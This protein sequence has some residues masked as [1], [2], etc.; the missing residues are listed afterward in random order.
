M[1]S[2]QVVSGIAL[3]ALLGCLSGPAFAQTLQPNAQRE[4]EAILQEKANRTPA[5]QKLDSHIHLAGQLARGAL[6]TATIPSLANAAV[7]LEFDQAGS[8]HVDI[9]ANVNAAL[10][11]QITALGGRVE[12]SFPDYRVIRAWIPLLAAEA[13][14]SRSDVNFVKP[15]AK[16]IHNGQ[17]LPGSSPIPRGLTPAQRRASIRRQLEA[18]VPAFAAKRALRRGLALFTRP[19][20][21]SGEVSEGV[22][23]ELSQG[24]TGTGVKIG[25][26]SDGVKSLA[27]LQAAG[28]LPNNVTVLSGQAGPPTGDEGT[29]MLEIIYDLAPNATLYFATADGGEAQ[30]ATNIQNLAVAGCSIIVDDV[31][32]FDEGVFQDGII[33]QAVNAVTASGVLYFSAAGNSGNLDSGTSGTWEGDFTP[34]GSITITGGKFGAG[35]TVP[36]HAFD[37]THI[38][39][40]ITV[41]SSNSSPTL[42]KWSDPLGASCNDYDLFILDSTGTTIKQTSTNYQTCTQDPL[43]GVNAP[44]AGDLVVIILFQGVQRALHLDTERARLAIGTPGATFGHNA[45]ATALAIAATHAQPTI[46]TSGNQSPESYS[47]DGPRKIFYNPNGSA[48]TPGNFLFS[49]NGGTTLPKV[50]FTA[51]DCGQSAVPTFNPFC[52]TSAA[53]PVAASIAALIHSA[54]PYLTSGQVVTL[55]RTMALAVHAGFNNRTGGAGI[56]MANLAVNASLVQ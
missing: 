28:D 16:M 1:S 5:Q 32:Y 24:Y 38:A 36:L 9:Q 4:I 17:I 39:D 33:A 52:G 18:A 49:T 51:A 13:L 34:G 26:L 11:A 19:I 46:F 30:F 37:A 35:T 22:D 56:V 20:D 3:A 47:S 21:V 10:L 41:G 50:D 23:L 14:A 6:T 15:A 43:E 48:I 29:A 31:T 27:T 45:A 25:V 53:A 40:V 12:S 44:A 7:G 54:N 42:L 8:V 2:R 55:M